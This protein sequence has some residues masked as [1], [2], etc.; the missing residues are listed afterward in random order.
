LCNSRATLSSSFGHLR[1]A[2]DGGNSKP[3]RNRALDYSI[4]EIKV[5][6]RLFTRHNKLLSSKHSGSVSQ[7]DNCLKNLRQNCSG[8]AMKH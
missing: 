6:I 3:K 8:Q 2:K 4:K 7:K 5:I 1:S